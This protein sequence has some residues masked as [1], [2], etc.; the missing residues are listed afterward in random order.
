MS[1]A[2]EKQAAGGYQPPQRGGRYENVLLA[3]A[4]LVLGHEF[5]GTVAAVGAG[6]TTV[7]VGDRVAIEPNYRCGKCPACREGRYHTCEHFGFVGLMGDGGMAEYAVVPEAMAH[8]LPATVGLAAAAV[9]EPAAVA[10]HAV[11]R[12]GP[13]IGRTAVVV[14]LGPV[15]LLVCRLL[16]I[17]GARRVRRGQRRTDHHRQRRIQ[18]LPYGIDRSGRLGVARSRPLHHRRGRPRRS[19]GGAA[20]HGGRWWA[21]P[22]DTRALR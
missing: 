8:V 17:F 7:A 21:W 19:A 4:P 9:L 5:S 14:G 22:Q 2:S 3:T 12:A 15:G 13:V 6:V 10:L 16:R 11:R 1:L 18:R 20:Q